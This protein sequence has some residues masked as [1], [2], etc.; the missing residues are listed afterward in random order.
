[1]TTFA[2]QVTD[3]S[4]TTTMVTHF[5]L[6]PM[7]AQ[8]HIIPMTD[9]AR[10]LAESGAQVSLVTTPVNAARMAGF[11][12]A[13][14]EAGLPVQLLELPFPAAE[15]GLPDGCENMD[16]V[17]SKDLFKNFVEACG[18]LREPLAA[19]LRQQRP[20]PSCVISDVMHWWTGDIARE[21]GIPRLTFNGFCN[22][23]LPC[24][25]KI[26]QKGQVL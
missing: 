26:I 12:A 14:E 18:A 13:V 5:V 9:L 17:P 11:V 6:V 1:M 3:G 22:L 20:P 16:M 19:C 25:V 2:G 4:T 21:L 10:L 24:Q 7:M 8:G 15:Y 23:R